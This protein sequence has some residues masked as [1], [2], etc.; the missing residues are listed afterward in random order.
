MWLIIQISDTFL[1]RR[2]QLL[3][4]IDIKFF[5]TNCYTFTYLYSLFIILSPWIPI[6]LCQYHC[7]TFGNLSWFLL[8]FSARRI[9]THDHHYYSFFVYQWKVV[10]MIYINLSPRLYVTKTLLCYFSR[11]RQWNLVLFLQSTHLHYLYW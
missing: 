1:K 9:F 2:A 10:W 4:L 5:G 7:D 6:G 3:P 8:A 11:R